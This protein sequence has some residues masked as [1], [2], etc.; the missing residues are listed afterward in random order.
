MLG[1]DRGDRLHHPARLDTL[2]RKQVVE[3]RALDLGAAQLRAQGRGHPHRDHRE[4]LIVR[5]VQTGDAQHLAVGRQVQHLGDVGRG[6]FERELEDSTTGLG[7]RGLER[8]LDRRHPPEGLPHRVHGHEPA[9]PL[10]GR[11]EPFVTQQLERPPD[12]DPAHAVLPPQLGL[13]GQGAAG[14]G[15]DPVPQGVGELHVTHHLYRTCFVNP[16]TNDLLISAGSSDLYP[17]SLLDT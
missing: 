13:A 5:E 16:N 6:R 10:A 17:L 4:R 1:R 11:D 12:R 15:D 8:R 3:R 14:P 9:D 2:Q 7:T